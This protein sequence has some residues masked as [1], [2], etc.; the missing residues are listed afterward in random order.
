MRRNLVTPVLACLLLLGGITAS[1]GQTTVLNYTNQWSYLVTNAL[2]PGGW[3]NVSYP[4]A[5]GWPVG[6]AAFAYPSNEPMPGG[7]SLQTVLDTNFNGNYVTSFYFRTTF[8]LPSN[9]SN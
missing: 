1:I 5:A 8:N 6:R 3:T 4:A 2:P 9:P 7:V